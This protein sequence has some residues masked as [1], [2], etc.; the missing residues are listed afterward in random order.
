MAT[1]AI[2]QDLTGH[3]QKVNLFKIN[4]FVESLTVLLDSGHDLLTLTTAQPL[5][6]CLFPVIVILINNLV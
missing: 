4:P 1:L 2:S 6:I 3:Y 5:S